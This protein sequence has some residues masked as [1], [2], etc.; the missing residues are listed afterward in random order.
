M[1]A[2]GD[3]TVIGR[4]NYNYIFDQGYGF[5]HLQNLQSNSAFIVQHGT[6]DI[7]VNVSNEMDV[8][9][10]GIGNVYYAGNPVITQTSTGGGKL[11]HD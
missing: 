10:T 3:M 1:G 4:T 2:G 7:H 6:G 11:I 8:E 5:L 9:I